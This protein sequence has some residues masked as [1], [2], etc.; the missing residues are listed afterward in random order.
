MQKFTSIKQFRTVV[1]QVNRYSHNHEK[2]LPKIEYTGTVK[3]HGTNAGIRRKPSGKIIPQCRTRIL[4]VS[5]DNYGFATFVESNMDSIVNLFETFFQPTDDVTLYGE[6]CGRGIQSGVAVSQLEKH[7][8]LVSTAINGIYN[9]LYY[10]LPEGLHYNDG[11]IFSV[12]QIPTYNITIDFANPNSAISEINELTLKVEDECPWGKFRGV[13]GIGEGICWVPTHIPQI[14]DLWFKTKGGKHCGKSKTNGIKARISVEEANSINECLDIVLPE[15][16]L[17][18][19][20]T[21]LKDHEISIEM[22]FIGQYIKWINEDV[23][24]EDLDTI[25]ENGFE[26]KKFNKFVTNRAKQY[27][28]NVINDE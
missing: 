4:D 3:I 24:K 21:Y 1:A 27:F 6:F 16:K 13:S 8:V 9:E 12:F 2:P 22:K 20:I 5:N 19:G 14:T 28:L 25:T 11:N 10:P 23:I 15:W 18:Q 17:Q 26:W 7:L